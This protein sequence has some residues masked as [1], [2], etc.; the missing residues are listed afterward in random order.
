MCK[1]CGFPIEAGDHYVEAIKAQWHETCFICTVSG[2]LQSTVFTVALWPAVASRESP[3][4]GPKHL[5][6]Y[7]A[8]P[9]ACCFLHK[10]RCFGAAERW[11]SKTRSPP[12]VSCDALRYQLVIILF[13]LCR[14]HEPRW[15]RKACWH[16]FRWRT[17]LWKAVLTSCC[18]RWSLKAS[19]DS[20]QQINEECW[21]F[22][23]R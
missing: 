4:L 13:L 22:V 18:Q 16:F 7:S 15:L 19:S 23:Q 9:R 17:D 2:V 6:L 14:D 10:I 11:I 3:L 21:L 8:L 1:G 5:L 20:W 12:S